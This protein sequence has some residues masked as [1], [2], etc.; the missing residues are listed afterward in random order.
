MNTVMLCGGITC[1]VFTFAI[2]FI[3]GLC[4]LPV[5]G[6]LICSSFSKGEF[7]EINY[8]VRIWVKKFLKALLRHTIG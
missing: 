2:N 5:S 6:M 1:L 7:K 3:I 8:K 4:M